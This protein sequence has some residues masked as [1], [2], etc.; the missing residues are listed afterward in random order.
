MA[1]DVTWT[2]VTFQGDLQG[3]TSFEH[4]PIR[5][6]HWIGQFD[7]TTNSYPAI[8]YTHIAETLQVV[9]SI[10]EAHKDHPAIWGL[11]P[12]NEPWQF[13]PLEPLKK[14][15]WDAYHVVRAGAPSWTFVMHDS[16]RGYPAAWWNFM[17]GCPKKAMDSHIYQGVPMS[18]PSAPH[19][20]FVRGLQCAFPLHCALNLC[21]SLLSRGRVHVPLTAWNRPGVME[22][23]YSNAC[24]FRNTVRTMEEQVDMPLIV[25]EWSLATDNCAMWLN[26]FNDN[27]PGYPKVSCRMFPC[28]E[29]YMGYEQPGTPPDPEQPL[30]GP[31]GTGV[32]GPQFGECPV[33]VKWGEKEDEFM[34]NLAFKHL[35]SFNSVN[36]RL[37][38]TAQPSSPPPPAP[39]ART[40]NACRPSLTACPT[41][42]PCR[43]MVGSSG[44]FARRWSRNGASTVPTLRAGSP[45][46]SRM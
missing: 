27:L 25:G 5:A 13:I 7:R 32:S 36:A 20:P 17:K 24:G 46:M 22:T 33:D 1:A 6:A 44:T 16:F 39:T 4:W 23:Y 11:E 40:A 30:Q 19:L 3:I 14:F 10:V 12:V 15:Y 45:A 34:M 42:G 18:T 41:V 8:N 43:D 35:S 9:K 29:P 21:Q 28:A 37:S 2:S 31:F 26:G 38:P